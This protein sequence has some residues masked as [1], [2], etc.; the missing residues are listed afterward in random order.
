MT[1][2]VPTYPTPYYPPSAPNLFG[3]GEFKAAGIYN[4]VD[5][6]ADPTGVRD[7]TAAALAAGKDVVKNG[8]GLR[9]WPPGTYIINNLSTPS[10]S[11]GFIWDCGAGRDITILKSTLAGDHTIAQQMPAHISDLTVDGG[12]LT[13][14]CLYQS[15]FAGVPISQF[16]ASRIRCTNNAP[17]ANGWVHAVWDTSS[18]YLIDRCYL[19]DV[20]WE[21]PSSSSTD[22]ATVSYV[23]TCF[24]SNLVTS[25]VY[26]T[27]N[28]YVMKRLY[29]NNADIGDVSSLACFVIDS[30]V[31]YAEL[32]NIHVPAVA[33]YPIWFSALRMLGN[34]VRANRIIITGVN[35]SQTISITN[36]DISEGIQIAAPVQQVTII[37][38]TVG[39]GTAG[40]ALTDTAA[41]GTLMGNVTAIG[42]QFTKGLGDWFHSN[43]GNT[44]KNVD[45]RGGVLIP[46]TSPYVLFN[47]VTLESSHLSIAGYNPVGPVVVAVPAT[48]VATAALP[49]DATFYITQAT[50]ASSV[51][52]QGQSIAIPI[53][54][55]TAVRVPAGETLTP[56]Y[57]T[58]PTWVV[59]GE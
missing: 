59:M 42:T 1:L 21:G 50:A 47:G 27:P 4:V 55:P 41:A 23:N 35:A 3:G 9:Y 30:G 12:G 51:A 33:V 5:Y 28:F 34:G 26:R 45:I 53:G 46:P 6:G 15:T 56:T 14:T 7:S 57:T 58:A 8:G 17:N 31:D 37:G 39:C 49:Y 29:I 36:P 32:T 11:T 13:Q 10:Q 16:S 38:G 54:G 20:L 19:E 18:G 44:W 24:V 48:T 2:P 25:G 43:N 40:G 22:A 52:V